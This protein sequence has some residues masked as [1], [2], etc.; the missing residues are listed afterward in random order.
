VRATAR[1]Q[2]DRSRAGLLSPGLP[3]G[4]SAPLPTCLLPS[5]LT[6]CLL[7]LRPPPSCIPVACPCLPASP[8]HN[9][10][11]RGSQPLPLPLP[12]PP[13]PAQVPLTCPCPPASVPAT[14]DRPSPQGFEA[15]PAPPLPPPLPPH[16]CRIVGHAGVQRRHLWA[17]GAAQARR[18]CGRLPLL[19]S[20]Q[21]R[22]PHMAWRS[23]M[24]GASW[25][26][27]PAGC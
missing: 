5:P 3:Q 22:G 26:H 25:A 10:C 17:G 1:R 8:F 27:P 23:W 13:R 6:P 21:T 11:A 19:H 15:S 16:G 2:E 18:R 7:P 24:H 12:P 14:L 4:I 9:P 20:C